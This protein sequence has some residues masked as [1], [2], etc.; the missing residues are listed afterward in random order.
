MIFFGGGGISHSTKNL[1]FV[2]SNIIG[3][4]RPS[5]MSTTRLN[6]KLDQLNRKS[7]DL[8]KAVRAM[9]RDLAQK[10]ERLLLQIESFRVITAEVRTMHDDDL[11]KRT[12]DIRKENEE[13]KA[14]LE[15]MSLEEPEPEDPSL[16]KAQTVAIFDSVLFAIENWSTDGD[17]APDFSLACQAILFPLVYDPVMNGNSNYFLRKVPDSALEVVKRGRE[18]VKFIRDTCQVGLTDPTA[19]SQYV[20][21][22][23]KWWVN[24]A[25][26]LLYGARDDVWERSSPLTLEAI[27]SWR[28]QP[29]S[30]PLDFPLVF[31]AMDLLDRHG[32]EI[33]EKT[34]LPQFTRDTLNTRLEAN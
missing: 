30:R 29:A 23:S 20:P 16:V 7:F 4:Q 31:D 24:D 10:C 21:M 8:E 18:Y 26:P 27:I 2:F 17:T 14:K 6:Y 1:S 33:R 9:E 5:F 28:D 22:I 11:E 13:L 25:L 15:N 32:D 3:K 34:N 12:K 19:W